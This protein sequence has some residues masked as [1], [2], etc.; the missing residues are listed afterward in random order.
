M[1]DLGPLDLAVPVIVLIITIVY[2]FITFVVLLRNLEL[3]QLIS[4]HA[5]RQAWFERC[6]VFFGSASKPLFA[7]DVEAT[8]DEARGIVL[9]IGTGSGDWLYLLAPPRNE[10]ILTLILLEPNR[11]FHGVLRMR[12]EKL[13]LAGRYEII[14][15]GIKDLERIGVQTGTI[16][17]ITTVHVLCSVEAPQ[18]LVKRLY[19]YLK[20]GGQ[21]LVYEHIK[22]RNEKSL[23]AHWQ[24]DFLLH[25]GEWKSADLRPG[26]KEGRFNQLPHT[27]GRLVKRGS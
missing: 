21:S 17:T 7:K 22:T 15:G 14:D 25:A 3:S 24:E 23:P 8:L 9:D 6:W 1:L 4:R 18:A 26:P 27:V 20:P 2:L 13:G 12:A 10:H 19:A 5:F 11:N 16:D